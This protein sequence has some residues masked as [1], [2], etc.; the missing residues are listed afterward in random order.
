MTVRREHRRARALV[1]LR[2]QL[3]RMGE[4]KLGELVRT[5][6]ELEKSRAEAMRRLQQVAGPDA[7]SWLRH[8]ER[9]GRDIAALAEPIETAERDQQV[10]ARGEQLA[11]DWRDEAGRRVERED[12]RR[13]LEE[14]AE[15]VGWVRDASLG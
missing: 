10:A 8:I 12:E 6:L 4:L 9:I 5:R 13:A 14:I 2:T 3:R 15:R 7:I 11:L 1:H